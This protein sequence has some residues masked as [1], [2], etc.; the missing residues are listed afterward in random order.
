MTRK[1][2]DLKRVVTNGYDL[3]VC[4]HPQ[5]MLNPNVTALEGR[6]SGGD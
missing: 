1:T 4:D 3:N 2:K 5:F 6:G